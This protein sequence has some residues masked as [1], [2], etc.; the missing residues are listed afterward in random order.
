MLLPL[1]SHCRAGNSIHFLTQER[2][3][4]PLTPKPTVTTPASCSALDQRAAGISGGSPR[5]FSTGQVSLQSPRLSHCQSMAA[6]ALEK[7]KPRRIDFLLLQAMLCE[8]S[9]PLT[10]QELCSVQEASV[11][12]GWV[13]VWGM[14][15][16]IRTVSS[17]GIC[18]CHLHH[19][20]IFLC[21]AV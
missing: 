5:G 12:A 21:A 11:L 19:V 7:F 9:F 3:S 15:V 17:A 18:L 16:S 4:A 20:C 10:A 13:R 14:D 8:G 2:S 6:R 1:S